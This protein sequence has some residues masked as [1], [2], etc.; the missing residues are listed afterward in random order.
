MHPDKNE[1]TNN[2]NFKGKQYIEREIVTFG[3]AGKIHH[4]NHFFIPNFL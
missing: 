2:H 1:N 3:N 4:F